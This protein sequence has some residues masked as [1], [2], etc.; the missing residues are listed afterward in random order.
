MV[1]EILEKEGVSRLWRGNSA[2]VLRILPYSGIQFA[3][4]RQAK[5][6]FKRQGFD[7]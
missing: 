4:H 1:K 6:F 7:P 5:Y 3:S 2:T